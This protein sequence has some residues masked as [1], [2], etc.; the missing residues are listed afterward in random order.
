MVEQIKYIKGYKY[1]LYETYSIQTTILGFDMEARFLKL[2]TN[3]ILTC[4]AG[5]AWDGPSGPAMDTQ[6][7][8]RGSLVH[9][10]LYQLMRLRYIPRTNRAYADKLMKRVCLEDKMNRFR[11]A[12][13]Y[14]FVRTFSNAYTD[15]DRARPILVAPRGISNET[16]IVRIDRNN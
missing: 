6:D 12:Y 4:I 10:A 16:Q 14:W 15:P 1:Q 7:F 13:V 11:V 8:M 9:D 5:Y 3:G 2:T